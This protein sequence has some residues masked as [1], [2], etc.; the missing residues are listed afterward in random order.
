MSIDEALKQLSFVS[1]TG[2]KIVK[3]VSDTCFDGLVQDYSISIA[4]AMEILQSCT[5]P[6]ICCCI[7]QHYFSIWCYMD[8]NKVIFND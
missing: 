5:K 8:Y 3:E 7:M 6:S 1:R 2:S 4:N